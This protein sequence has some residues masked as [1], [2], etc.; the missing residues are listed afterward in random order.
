MAKKRVKISLS[1]MLQSWQIPNLEVCMLI[2]VVVGGV[3]PLIVTMVS[4]RAVNLIST[5]ARNVILP[6]PFG[7]SP[8][9][10]LR[11]D[12]KDYYSRGYDLPTS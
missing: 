1:G 2:T 5:N 6:V 8:D 4:L 3:R 7:R 10:Q 9:F 11:S 12:G